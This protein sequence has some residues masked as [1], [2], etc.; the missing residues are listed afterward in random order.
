MIRYQED[1]VFE[2]PSP[3]CPKC[4]QESLIEAEDFHIM[5]IK[6]PDA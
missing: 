4:R 2:K 3:C 1:T 6:E 5:V